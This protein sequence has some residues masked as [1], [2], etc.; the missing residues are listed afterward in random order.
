MVLCDWGCRPRSSV[1]L[2]LLSVSHREGNLVAATPTETK[3][4]VL[5]LSTPP[6]PPITVLPPPPTKFPLSTGSPEEEKGRG[7]KFE[8]AQDG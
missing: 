3:L 4:L 6:L 5:S 1:S 8:T 7:E 2:G